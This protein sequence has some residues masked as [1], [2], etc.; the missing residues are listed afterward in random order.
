MS[1]INN[2][3]SDTVIIKSEFTGVHSYSESRKVIIFLLNSLLAAKKKKWKLIILDDDL[4]IQLMETCILNE[5]HIPFEVIKL[6]EINDYIFEGKRKF[7][8]SFF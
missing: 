3:I 6:L 5:I 2:F 7:K 4:K 8:V 1:N